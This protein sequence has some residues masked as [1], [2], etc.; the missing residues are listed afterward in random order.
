[1]QWFIMK[2]ISALLSSIVDQLT[3]PI[4]Q[5]LMHLENISFLQEI[6]I[7]M[8]LLK[9]CINCAIIG[10]MLINYRLYFA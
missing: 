4:A 10:F 8:D 5:I 7:L 3:L 1:M 6:E 9:I 2:R